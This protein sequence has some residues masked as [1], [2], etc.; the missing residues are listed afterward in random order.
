MKLKIVNS[1]EIVFNIFRMDV[2]KTATGPVC[3]KMIRLLLP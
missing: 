2:R 3:E 1:S